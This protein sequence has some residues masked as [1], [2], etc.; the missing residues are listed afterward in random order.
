MQYP[1]R[2]AITV[3]LVL[4]I[5]AAG[6]KFYSFFPAQTADR[7]L[8][9]HEP[10]RKN[11]PKP[12][13]PVGPQFGKYRQGVVVAGKGEKPLAE[14]R[15]PRRGGVDLGIELS[16]VEPVWDVSNN[17]DAFFAALAKVERKEAGA[18]VRI[19]HYGDSPTTADLITADVR[20][21]LQRQF[22]DAGHGYYLIDKPWAWYAHRG[23]S[24]EAS[25]WESE[26]ATTARIRDGLYGYGGVSFRGSAGARARFRWA[27][28]AEHDEVEVGYFRQAQG[29]VVR[30]EACGVKLG[31]IET[32]G[33]A[34]SAFAKFSLDATCKELTLSVT[35]GRVRLYGISLRRDEG[36]VVYDSLGI[37]GAYISV[38]SKFLKPEHWGEQLRH[39]DPQLVVINYGTNESVY[40]A[41]V[42]KVFEKE[43]R[44]TIK[45]ARAAV[46][47]ASILV[48][49]PMDRGVRGASGAIETVPAIEK[50]VEIERRVAQEE[51][52]AFFSTFTAMGGNGTMRD[53]YEGTPRLVGADFIHPM[54]AG[55]KRIG[56]YLYRAL[57]DGFN[58][59]KSRR[60]GGVEVAG[61]APGTPGQ[62]N[63]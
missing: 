36:G 53:W 3:L 1:I 7:L 40:A 51:G 41:F 29:G 26:P 11:P 34:G 6:A 63:K 21:L 22:G 39:Y 9:F 52:V 47:Q 4:G 15:G 32:A 49:S 43:L 30:V 31:E 20:E 55:A 33:E 8:A 44:E 57:L 23:V 54:P 46:P 45:R 17:L 16:G 14:P 50:L 48:M 24:S 19:A 12:E 18:T 38:L 13:L 62:P 42:D 10:R 2:T 27:K 37:N 25:G 58:H 5:V 61:D 35:S 60:A 28:N 56:E 59:Y